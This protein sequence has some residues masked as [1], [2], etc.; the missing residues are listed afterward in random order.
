MPLDRSFGHWIARLY[1]SSQNH[2]ASKLAKLQ[3][4][5]GQHSFLLVLFRKDGIS[6]D[7]LARILHMNKAAVARALLKL[8]QNGYIERRKDEAD[9]RNNYVYLTKKA[10][11]IKQQLF[12]VVDAWT[13]T[14]AAGLTDADRDSLIELLKR[15]GDNADRASENK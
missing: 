3:I 2:H 14:L 12:E 10:K 7:N 1:R 9:L 15:M 11:D 5:R 4:G 8:E 13:D 6:Q